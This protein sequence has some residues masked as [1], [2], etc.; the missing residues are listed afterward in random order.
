MTSL[1]VTSAALEGPVDEAF[2]GGLFRIETGIRGMPAKRFSVSLY[3]SAALRIIA[4]E[5]LVRIAREGHVDRCNCP[6]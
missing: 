3:Q 4:S 5:P 2:A 1:Y 6:T